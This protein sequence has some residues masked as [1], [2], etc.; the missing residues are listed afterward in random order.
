MTLNIHSDLKSIKKIHNLQSLN[1]LNNTKLKIAIIG[2]SFNPAHHGHLAISNY[3]LNNLGF[4]YA[5]WLIAMQNPLK[6]RYDLDIFK[7]AQTA[8]ITFN[9]KIIIS[10]AEFDIIKHTKTTHTYNCLKFLIN[11]FSMVDFSWIIG[12]DN[13][14]N[15]NK[16]YRYQDIVDLCKII[17]LA[18]PGYNMCVNASKFPIHSNITF[19]YDIKSDIS[20]SQIKKNIIQ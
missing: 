6:H 3:A 15:F 14:Y 1:F 4:D 5:L 10:T 16:W 13:I 20:S 8:K 18:R 11:R 17:V 7:R 12:K 9:P 19:Y 2:G